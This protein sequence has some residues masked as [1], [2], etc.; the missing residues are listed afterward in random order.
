MFKKNKELKTMAAISLVLSVVGI[1]FAC[2][3]MNV[4][5]THQKTESIWDVS[6]VDLAVEKEG[7]ATSEQ[8]IVNLTSMSNVKAVLKNKND[9]VT[10]R[11]KIRNNG[12]VDAKLNVLSEIKPTCIVTDKNITN[13]TTM[14]ACSKFV[15]TLTYDNGSTIKP[16]DILKAGFNKELILVVQYLGDN[17]EIEVRD[18]D[19]M[20][21]FEQA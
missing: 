17:T 15:Y 21:L 6:F 5:L 19:F 13:T 3:A 7:T 9:S 4:A 20:L 11:F 10:Y 1:A 14:D 16:G 18:L 2:V 8:P 12:A